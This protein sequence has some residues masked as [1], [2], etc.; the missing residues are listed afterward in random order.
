[1]SLSRK[2]DGDCEEGT[3]L[4]EDFISSLQ[5][6]GLKKNKKKHIKRGREKQE[7]EKLQIGINGIHNERKNF[8]TR[9]PPKT[10]RLSHD[11]QYIVFNR[12]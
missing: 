10:H 9:P 3:V 4:L 8:F 5:E 2:S 1:M 11:V 12:P 6:P 7:L